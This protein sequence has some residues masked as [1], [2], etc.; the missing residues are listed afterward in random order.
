MGPR[1]CVRM[2]WVVASV[3]AAIAAGACGGAFATWRM[4]R[5][6]ENAAHD[7]QVARTLAWEGGE[8]VGVYLNG[9]RST[10]AKRYALAHYVAVLES[11]ASD[12]GV[13]ANVNGD[14]ALAY[15]RLSR[16][17][18]AA[19]EKDKAKRACEKSITA[20][21][22]SGHEF[23]CDDVLKRI[24]SFDRGVAAAEG[25]P[26]QAPDQGHSG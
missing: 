26:D 21:Q 11:Y 3:L 2:R 4:M 22:K 13:F 10:D 5:F 18:D 16:V 14:L 24:E 15:G 17:L 12:E 25:R 19:G 20:F 9:S 23:T 1:R 7:L 8:A 6:L